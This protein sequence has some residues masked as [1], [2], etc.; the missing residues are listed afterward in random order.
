MKKLIRIQA[1][2]SRIIEGKIFE[3]EL[4]LQEIVKDHPELIPLDELGEDI[5][6]ILII[7]REFS[8]GDAGLVDLLGIDIA[9]LLTIIEFKLEKNTMIREAVAQTL[10]Y[11]ANLWGMS[12]PELER[13]S[14]AYFGGDRCTI[15]DLKSAKSLEQALAWHHK[16]T[17]QE[18]DI[19][20]SGEEFKNK[21][22]T[23]LNKGEFRLIL[24]CDEV[25]SR[26]KKAVEYVHTLS[27]FDFYCA[28]AEFYDDAGVQYIRPI[29]VTKEREDKQTEKQHAGKI[30]YDE[31]IKAIPS[32]FQDYIPIYQGFIKDFDK[33]SGKIS[34]G[35]KGFAAYFPTSGDPL[36]LF[37]AYP[38]DIWII[39]KV[40]LGK[41]N[42]M[43]SFE[44]KQDFEESLKE[45]PHFKKALTTQGR[46]CKV[47]FNDISP[48]DIENLLKFYFGWHKKWFLDGKEISSREKPD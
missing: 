42:E 40:G 15:P 33:I 32:V 5:K 6:P 1:G 7:G 46:L 43:L 48:S 17:T 20:F 26:T 18:G 8:L 29:M 22:A 37:E 34:W 44:A 39:T 47:K 31:F 23:N 28:T 24:F 3:K 25:D 9:G 36:R 12:Y 10:E 2:Q 30:T 11:A 19:P 41:Y 4:E 14:L 27:R 21:V 13:K 45:M 38:D 16:R 35:T